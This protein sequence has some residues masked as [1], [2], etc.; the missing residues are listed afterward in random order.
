MAVGFPAKTSYVNGDVFSASDINDTNG[1]LNLLNP[2]TTN[3]SA[4]KN[5]IINGDFY[6]NQRNFSSTTT[7]N[8]Y[9][10]DRWQ[11]SAQNGTSTF[12]A[13]TFTPGAAP[14]VGYEGTNFIRI[15][16]TGQTASSASTQL[17]Q[18]IED[19]RNFAG[20]TVTVSLWAK[21]NTGTPKIA[22]EAQQNFGSG[23][24]STVNNYAGQITL[25]TSWTR[26][27]VTIAVPS[28]SGKTIG[29]SSYLGTN[30]WMSAG[31]DFN[32]RTGS[33]GIQTNTFEIWGVQVEAGS[34]ATAFQTATGSIEGELAACQ[35]YYVRLGGIGNN[36]AAYS[37]YGANGFVE[38]SVLARFTMI[39]PVQMRNMSNATIEYASLGVNDSV[40]A[41]WAISAL[42]LDQTI[43]T[44]TGLNATI[45]GATAGRPARIINNNNTAGYIAVS[46]EL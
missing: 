1:T 17:R 40:N 41:T 19:V 33:L 22:I 24:S 45:S 37:S 31:T 5:K 46:A 12:S 34:F 6:V 15:A 2:A 23:G 26:Y 42:T 16:T 13:Q 43:P 11:T 32:A 8:F 18:R 3:F 30:L 7:D 44:A 39:F 14:V 27:S 10:F 35:R 36:A 28:V 29:A 38:S 4:G 20:Q 9:T 25:S 21:A